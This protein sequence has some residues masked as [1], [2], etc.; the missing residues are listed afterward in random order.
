VYE[1]YYKYEIQFSTYSK[2]SNGYSQAV[3]KDNKQRFS[4][5]EENGEL[6]IRANQGHTTTV[7]YTL[8]IKCSLIEFGY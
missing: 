8:F 4:L 2:L 5:M 3:R 6:L 7:K 1:K